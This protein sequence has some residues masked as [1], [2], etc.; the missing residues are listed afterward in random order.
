MDF[1]EALVAH[2]VSWLTI[3]VE[4]VQAPLYDG[5]KVQIISNPKGLS[6][7]LFPTYRG[8]QIRCFVTH[9]LPVYWYLYQ[10]QLSLIDANANAID[11]FDK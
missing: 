4:W 10:T 8:D 9:T 5:C 1:I 3:S 7:D 6:C 11:I 2:S